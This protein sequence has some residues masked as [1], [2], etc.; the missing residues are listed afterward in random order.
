MTDQDPALEEQ[1]RQGELRLQRILKV[2]IA[3]MSLLIVGGIVVVIA[4]ALGGGLDT[5]REDGFDITVDAPGEI[6]ALS[7]SDGSLAV[8][9]QGES[10]QE[11]IVFDVERGRERGRIRFQAAE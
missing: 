4:A 10:G 1:R 11:V 9:T 5:A 6:G 3:V 7:L 2:A 8:L